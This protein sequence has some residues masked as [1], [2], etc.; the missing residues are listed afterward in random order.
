[1]ILGVVSADHQLATAN[2]LGTELWGGAGWARIG[3]YLPAYRAHFGQ[4]AVGTLG[5]NKDGLIVRTD[6]GIVRPD[7]ILM[8]RLMV[9]GVEHGIRAGQEKGQVII[10]DIDDW[11]FGLSPANMA[12]YHSHPKIN[13][14]ENT[15]HYAK[16]LAASDHVVAST[17]YLRERVSSM[18]NKPVHLIPNYVDIARFT[19]VTQ[20]V[21]PTL[22]WVGATAFRSNDLETLRGIV[23]PFIDRGDYRLHHSGTGYMMDPALDPF[24]SMIGVN[25]LQVSTSKMMTNAVDYPSLLDGFDV[26]LV[27]LA[28]RAFNHAKSVIKGLEYAAAGIPFVAAD[29]P[30][31]RELWESWEGEGFKLAKRPKDWIKALSYYR[32]YDH[33]L[34]AQ[35]QL[36]DRIKQ[37]DVQ[38]GEQEWISLME[39]VCNV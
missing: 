39:K 14:R 17:P 5:R 15:H 2:A 26:G 33:R 35:A 7:V 11:Y 29:L 20:Q 16:I 23:K 31:Y 4:V 13:E 9:T 3:Q 28:D 10:N 36:L 34:E 1:M 8:Q 6:T 27:P 25:Q 24:A 18:L 22:G 12:F 30:Q 32:D 19:P 21:E 38:Y 37:H